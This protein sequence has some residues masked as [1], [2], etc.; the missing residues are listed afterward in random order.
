[1]GFAKAANFVSALDE[2]R[3]YSTKTVETKYARRT[4]AHLV[5]MDQIGPA[6]KKE[7]DIVLEEK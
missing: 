3:C 4:L 7:Y 5:A 2:G 6:V 1:M